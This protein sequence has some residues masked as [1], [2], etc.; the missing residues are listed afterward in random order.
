MRL[1]VITGTPGTGKTTVSRI[2]AER[3]GWLHVDLTSCV[4]ENR[5]FTRFDRER[6]TYVVDMAR[7]RGY[8]ER[9]LGHGGEG[10]AIV[11]GHYAAEAIPETLHPLVKCVFVFR[12]NPLVLWE[13]LAR[14]G[15]GVGKVKEN[16]EAELVGVCLSSALAIF[17]PQ[18]V[19]EVDTTSST[20][21]EVASI[22][23]NVVMGVCAIPRGPRI[24]WLSSPDV[25][26]VLELL[27]SP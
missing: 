14:R 17:D 11:E 25:F 9:L 18:M 3:E 21:E 8:L 5:L 24:D 6:E 26:K 22:V 2:L 4:L 27:S 16:V 20:P 7:L 15:Y 23:R 13:R 10:V 1:L 19:Y 12:T